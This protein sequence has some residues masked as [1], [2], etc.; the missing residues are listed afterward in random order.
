MKTLIASLG[1][2]SSRRR[3]SGQLLPIAAVAFLLMCGLA[4]LAIDSSRDYL[5]KRQA[6]NAAD[7]AILAAAKQLSLSGSLNGP[8]A[9][10]SNPVKVA[11][12]F[13]ANNGFATNYSNA[14]DSVGA[15]FTT[16]WFDVGGL[17]CNAT[18]GF[19][20]KVTINSPPVGFAG[21]PV[22]SACAGSGRFACLQ[23]VIAA[24]IP[25]LFTSILGI[26]TAYVTVAATAQV[27]LPASAFSTPPPN[28]LILYQPQAGCNEAEQQCFDETRAV[29]R[30]LLACS[31]TNNC[32]TFWTTATVS[33]Y[34]FDG[35]TLTPPAD[36]TTLQS[37]GDM[38][39]QQR[40]T[41]C[42][43]YNGA[44]CAQN[45][46]VGARGFAT[47]GG[48]KLYCQR[49]GGGAV[50]LTPC[51]TTGQAGLQ[52]LDASQTFFSPQYYWTPAVDT[53]GLSSCGSLV[54]NG[55]PVNGPCADAQ[56]AYTIDPG[57]YGSI[58]INHGTYDFETGLFD[59]TGNAT[60]NTVTAGT[61]TANGIDH[62]RETAADF[63]LCTGGQPNSCPTLTAGVWIGHG[64][65]WSGAFVPPTSGTCI[66]SVGGGSSGGGGDATVV[67]GSG[68]VFR[69]EP[70]A[71]GFVSTNEVQGLTLSGAGVGA[72]PAV[73]GSPLIFDSENSTFIHLDARASSSNLITGVVYQ[74]PSATGGGVEMNLGMT[75]GG[76]NPALV[77]QILAYSF[78]AF[79]QT[80]T[81]DF[82]NGYGTSSLPGIATSG[83]NEP[84]IINSVSLA[85]AVGQLNYSTLTIN[86]TDEWSMDAFDTYLKVNNGNPIF[87]SQG[88]WNSAPGPGSPLPPP[89]NNPGDQYPAYPT[90]SGAYTIISNSPPDWVYNIPNSGGAT[91]EVKGSWAW[92]HESD[93][94][95][96]NRGAY[97][98]QILYTFPNPSGNYIGISVFTTDGDHCGDYQ[99]ANY[100]F[101]NTGQPGGG[102]QTIGS[103]SLVQ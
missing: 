53:S 13:A 72:L 11:H 60:V 62:S 92:G 38:V 21:Y 39:M 76:G 65:G 9:P 59:I 98:A 36:M 6:Q 18:T 83:R 80:G 17:P 33:I 48:S 101:R 81:M 94:P 41:I 7:F 85:A 15:G 64:G 22:P 90:S 95:G 61:Y 4:G 8:V 70:G 47:A 88:I 67:S 10:N 37:N 46:V 49:F 24:A 16:T 5:V 100:T 51:T 89:G 57:R 102:T 40:T 43:P 14:C 52:E 78:T 1:L 34:G 25:Q 26:P 93:I 45:R 91:I 74:A 31:G 66:G 84:S 19:T 2:D 58:V 63:D 35:V 82:R 99:I 73:G 71:G 29:G 27:T 75:S 56:E 77:G 55:G 69:L 44:A 12:D 79:G 20:N 96:A 23:V 28:A 86:Y 32:P 54:L 103:V 87:F 68:V 42:D 3:Q 30:A 50:I 97:T